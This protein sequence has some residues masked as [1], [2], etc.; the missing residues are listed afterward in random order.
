MSVDSK[1]TDCLF[2]MHREQCEV[3]SEDA[4][5]KLRDKTH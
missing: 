1:S 3:G 4:G 5:M 2:H